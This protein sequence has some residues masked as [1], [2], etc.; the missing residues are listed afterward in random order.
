MIKKWLPVACLLSALAVVAWLGPQLVQA[1]ESDDAEVVLSGLNGPQGVL[2]APDGTVWAIDAGLGG[3]ET[4]EGVDPVSGEVADMAFGQTARVVRTTADGGQE[5]VA[6]LPSVLF[7]EEFVGGARLAL[8]DDVLY[9]T[10]GFW[11]GHES[12]LTPAEPGMAAIMRIEDGEATEVVNLSSFERRMNPD[13]TIYES[14]PYGMAVD[15]DGRLWVADAGA[16][17]MLRV[18]PETRSVELMTVFGPIPG[19]FPSPTRGGELLADPVPTGVTFDDEGNLYVSYL[20]GAPFVPG[21][22]K[23]VRIQNNQ[24]VD[25]ATGLTMLTDLRTAPNGDMFAVQFA[26]F[27]EEGPQMNSGAIVRVLPGEDSEVVLEGLS[28]P[29]SIDFNEDGDAYIAI[30]GV[31]PPGS[32]AVIRVA[33]LMNAEAV[34][35][36]V[37]EAEATETPVAEEEPE[38][39]ET[40]VAE[41]EPV[42]EAEPE[43]TATPAAEEE[44]EATETP[45]AEEEAVDEVE[46]TATPVVEE[47]PEPTETPAAE[48]EPEATETPVAEE[49]PEAT[50]TPVAE[51]EA[52]VAEATET[53][54]AEEESPATETPA[55]EEEPVE[56]VI[57]EPTATPVAE[58]EVETAEATETPIAEEEPVE[59]MEPEATET[60]V[61]EEEPEATETPVVEEEPVE[62]MEPEATATPVAEEE[63]A[64]EEDMAPGTLPATGGPGTSLPLAVGVVMLVV[65]AL[66]LNVWREKRMAV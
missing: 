7:G 11:T 2:V 50:A 29:T 47:E 3:E 64:E 17:T 48:E 18:N 4:L 62:E 36:E 23:V 52:E 28:F 20:S 46:P 57:L 54:V 13:G 21:S 26:L 31:G 14:H 63:E 60:P 49:E 61:A 9:A 34:A 55:A 65:A 22:A 1:Q 27:T 15:E 24:P 51:E 19:V 37:A 42:E 58:E 30:N 35:A 6:A 10:N 66:A 40:P 41:E 33:D 45:V 44:P 8:V 16:N 43:A 38:A 5:D 39:T 56:E 12:N 53:P 25:Y 59:E 32:G